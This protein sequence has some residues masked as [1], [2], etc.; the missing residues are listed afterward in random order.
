[1]SRMHNSPPDPALAALARQIADGTWALVI[2]A[3]AVDPPAPLESMVFALFTPRTGVDVLGAPAAMAQR[4]QPLA[5]AYT[6]NQA[7]ERL[8][9]VA[10]Q[11][12]AILAV[13]LPANMF[14]VVIETASG[15]QVL[16]APVTVLPIEHVRAQ[17]THHL[18]LAT[19]DDEGRCEGDAL[20]AQGGAA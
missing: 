3:M 5:S 15:W 6:I 4:T 18:A 12:D 10:P 7:R 13:D 14:R 8:G 20:T 16:V 9:R 2:A 1:M 11:L 19:V 17:A